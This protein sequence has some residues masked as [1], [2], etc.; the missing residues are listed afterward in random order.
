MLQRE[1]IIHNWRKKLFVICVFMA[2]FGTV[3]E[4][5]IYLVDAGTSELFLPNRL[6]RIRFIYIPT[7]ANLVVILITYFCL[8]S[9]KLSSA[10]KNVWSCIL[11]FFLCANMQILHYVY[12]SLSTLPVVA[13]MISSIFANRLLTLWLS[14]AS[15]I[16]LGVNAAF[17]ITELRKD[18]PWLLAEIALAYAVIWVSYVASRLLTSFIAEQI[19]AVIN[20]RKRENKLI[21]EVKLDSLMGIGNRKSLSA[22]LDG[23][24]TSQS[25]NNHCY[26]M[27]LDIDHF[28]DINDTYGHT[29]GDEVLLALSEILHRHC[30]DDTPAFRY[31]GDEIIIILKDY[32]IEKCSVFADT[33]LLEFRSLSF[34]S[35]KDAHFT[36]SAGIAAYRE[37]ISM[38]SWIHTAD[39]LLYQV[40]Q[41]GR[42]RTRIQ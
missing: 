18:D 9:K 23:L 8:A 34:A 31:G 27:I 29:C 26:L 42:S 10:A 5:V 37:G 35:M 14:I 41:N 15:S 1:D 39:E 38:E 25:L 11:I 3:L 13:I 32:S 21:E 36:F 19:D 17:S 20:G 22:Y 30:T 40:K 33:L 28:K 4:V 6:Y 2:A 12:G 7:T 24:M 16:T